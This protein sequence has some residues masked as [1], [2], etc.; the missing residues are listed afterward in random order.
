MTSIH[1]TN[2]V[3]FY[4]NALQNEIIFSKKLTLFTS[5][6][7]KSIC[8]KH[9]KNDYPLKYQHNKESGRLPP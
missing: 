8:F 3:F 5:I 4:F 1:F 2:I 6:G 9:L 7:K